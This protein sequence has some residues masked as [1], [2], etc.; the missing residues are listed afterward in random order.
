MQKLKK[1]IS[2]VCVI[3]LFVTSFSIIKTSAASITTAYIEGT[4]VNVRTGPGTGYTSIEKLSNTSATVLDTITTSGGI[5]YKISYSGS[6]GISEGYIFYDSDYIRVV[7]YDPDADFETKISAF[8]ESYRD[9]LRSLHASYPNWEFVPDPIKLSFKEAVA[10]ESVEMRKQVNF[11]SQPVSWRSMGPGAYE[12]NTGKWI[13]TNGGWTGASREIVAYYM[14]PRNFLNSS[15]IYMFLQQSYDPNYQTEA[16][17]EKIVA[18][19]FLANGYSDSDDTAYNGSYIKVI[20][21]A[22]R[23]SGVNPYII[24]SKI[25]QEQGAQGSSNLISG[26]TSHGKYFNFMNWKASGSSEAEVIANGLQYAQNK[27]WSTRSASIIGGAELLADGYLEAGQNTYYYQDFNVKNPNKLWHQYAQAVHDARSKGT[28]IAKTYQNETDYS[29]NFLIPVF[30]SMPE[31]VS[32]KPVQNDTINNYYFDKIEVSG[33][34]PSFNMFTYYYDLQVWGDTSIYYELLP[35]TSYVGET[36]FN[37][38]KGSDNEIVLKVKSE[39]GYIMDY[40]IQIDASVDSVITI[41]S[42]RPP[43]ASV[44]IGD[45]NFDGQIT[46]RDLANVRLH[47]LNINYL[48]SDGMRAADTNNDG[49]VTTRDLANIRL[50]LLGI[51]NLT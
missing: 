21:E 39:S 33:L 3:A 29:L 12:W 7:T 42:T 10:L 24:A 8:P 30:S 27:G 5:W 32:P 28:S 22:A 25:I 44:K 49:T 17:L 46:T 15:E 4:D 37:V 45:V 26:T 19:S 47:L 40:V 48:S 2:L 43:E 35:N 16:G 20:M 18:G 6:S 9:A 34:T 13:T 51:K 50:Y 1:I 31:S 11:L 14:D 36:T 38:K 41:T 23:Q